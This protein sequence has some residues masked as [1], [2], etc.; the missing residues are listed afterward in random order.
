MN[1]HFSLVAQLQKELDEFNKPIEIA[2]INVGDNIRD[3]RKKGGTLDFSQKE[4][5]ET[6]EFYSNSKFLTG[7]LD[8]E[9]QRKVFLNI[10]NFRADVASKQIDLDVKDFVFIPE[11][12]SSVWGAFFLNSRFKQWAKKEHWGET[13]NAIVSDYPKYGTAVLKKVGDKIERIPI[14]SLVNPQ[15]A[16]SLRECEYVIQVHEKMSK[17]DI[18]ENEGWDKV[19]LEFGETATVYERYGSV[20]LDWY[21]DYKGEK[22]QDEDDDKVV[23]TMSI[24]CLVEKEEVGGKK[25]YEEN[26]LFCEKSTKK[27]RPYE[28]AHWKKQD[29]RWLGIGE[30]ENQ[31][32]NQVFRNMVAN[33]RKRGLM[34]ASKKIFQSTD[35]EVAKNLI[36]QVKDGDVMQIMPNGNITQV[37]V[38]SQSLAEFQQAENAWEE[39]SNQKSFTF[40]AV[41]GDTL[42]SGTPF[43][44]GVLMSNAANTHFALKRENLGLFFSRVVDN[45][46]FPIFK[47]QN[48]RE[49][50]LAYYGSEEGLEILK[51]ALTEMYINKEI[52]RQLLSGEIP[53]TELIKAE[54]EIDIEKRRELFVKIPEKTYDDLKVSTTL[55]ITGENVNVEKKMETLTNLYNIMVQ[56]GQMEKSNIVLKRILA[57]SGES[58]EALDT[59]EQPQQAPQPQPQPQGQPQ[60]QAMMGKA[61]AQTEDLTA[62][63]QN[64]L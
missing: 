34:W 41:T 10:C 14:R 36:K 61:K 13:I 25:R 20:P 45:L 47:K 12:T 11:D 29:G 56:S 22:V 23:E 43:R 39:N 8:A 55:V 48:K 18:E 33:M 4:I 6:I 52:K 54:I 7:P 26:I 44:L 3:L 9:G 42:P 27:D 24:I 53:H 15:D 49:H 17:A 38:A 1:N 50:T 32:E 31:F 35:S 46:L 2:S 58:T 59:M 40:E 62:I 28:E 60:G 30:I 64:Q 19:D 21:K 5:L 37:N 57:L 16:K 51:K 63:G